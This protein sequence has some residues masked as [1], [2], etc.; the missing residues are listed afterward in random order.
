MAKGF[1]NGARHSLRPEWD[2]PAYRPA[3]DSGESVKTHYGLFSKAPEKTITYHIFRALAKVR[4]RRKAKHNAVYT[5]LL[6]HPPHIIGL[7]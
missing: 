3:P 6:I 1:C 7:Y 4:R 2:D 5:V